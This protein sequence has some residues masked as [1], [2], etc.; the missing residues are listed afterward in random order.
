ME[1]NNLQKQID[2]LKKTIMKQNKIIEQLIERMTELANDFD[3]R[4]NDD[5][6]NEYGYSTYRTEKWNWK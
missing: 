3:R 2:E 4:E 1:N 6:L 5:C